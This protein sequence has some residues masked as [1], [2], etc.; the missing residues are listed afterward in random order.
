[1][2]M[3]ENIRPG[4]G[5]SSP[6]A[7]RAPPAYNAGVTPAPARL[8]VSPPE[9]PRDDGDRPSTAADLVLV[10]SGPGELSNW[11]VPMAR[12]ATT[13]AA[14]RGIDLRLSLILP[15]CQFASGQEIAF[16]ERQRLFSRILGPRA[17]LAVVAGVHRIRSGRPGS[18]L[19]LG[20]D[21]WYSAALARRVGLAAFA[22]AETPL[23][24]RR[25]HRFRRVFVPSRALADRL[26]S[27]GVPGE[28]V[29]VVGDLRVDHLVQF[30][31]AAAGARAGSRVALLPGS[32]RWI[33]EVF[34]PFLLETAAAMRAR[35]PDIVFSAVVSPFLPRDA[36]ARML[37]AHRAALRDLAVEVVRD[38]HTGDRL[39]ALGQSDLV[40]TLPGTNTV[41]LAILGTPM[42]V[43]LPLDHPG[44]I[45]TEGLS[46][47]LG[48]VP[49]LGRMIKGAMVWRFA[50]RPSL[51]AWPNREAGRELVP[52][53]VGRVS[54]ADVAHRALALLED[55]AGL[56]RT[57]RA[58]RGLYT[59]A[60]GVAERMLDEMAPHLAPVPAPHPGQR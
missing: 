41:E 58:L 29:S 60:P 32:R 47:W 5:N 42:V 57:A 17:C 53:L 51:V 56:E 14:A 38:D 1:M 24:R 21:F 12:S 46:E 6:M 31:A 39:A 2:I 49:G 23:V 15:P 33:V 8:R 45:R 4:P 27:D 26:I 10:S 18:V 9:T 22:Y 40:I 52:E 36:L 37:A 19:H 30:R 50:R 35:R 55:R 28:R 34:L 16:A 20:G 54:P 11:A 59:T 3:P 7:R 44:R 25:A 43:V 48:R 13:W